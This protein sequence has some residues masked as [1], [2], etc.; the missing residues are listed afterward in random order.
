MQAV[1]DVSTHNCVRLLWVL[2]R[3]NT[4]SNEEADKLAKQAA[5]VEYIGSEPALGFSTTA[6]RGTLKL[7]EHRKL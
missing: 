3:S 7:N 2:G 4:E 6:V 1:T 5:A